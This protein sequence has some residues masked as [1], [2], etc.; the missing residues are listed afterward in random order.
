MTMTDRDLVLA[1]LRGGADART[2]PARLGRALLELVRSGD[3]RVMAEAPPTAGEKSAQ[4]RAAAAL[5]AQ[6]YRNRRRGRILE[7]DRFTCRYCGVAV[8][9]RTAHV[10]HVVPRVKGGSDDAAN[11]A[12]SCRHCNLS[13]GPKSLEEWTS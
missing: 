9:L 3:V 5:R 13:K 4:Q 6:R 8:N 1:A 10:D 2:L 11:L 7:R 12:A